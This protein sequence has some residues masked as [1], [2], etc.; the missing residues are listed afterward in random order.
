MDKKSKGKLG[1]QIDRDATKNSSFHKSHKNVAE[2][3]RLNIPSTTECCAV[4]TTG[5]TQFNTACTNSVLVTDDLKSSEKC[6]EN[7]LRRKSQDIDDSAKPVICDSSFSSLD[8][9]NFVI[10]CMKRWKNQCITWDPA[11]VLKS[12]TERKRT[13][14]YSTLEGIP[15]HCIVNGVWPTQSENSSRKLEN[16]LRVFIYFSRELHGKEWSLRSLELCENLTHVTLVR[17]GLASL[18]GIQCCRNL[19]HIDVSQNKISSLSLDGMF[20]IKSLVAASNRLTSTNG[21]Q[22]CTGLVHCDLSN[23]NI[24]KITGVEDCIDLTHLNLSN[25]QLIKLSGLENSKHLIFLEL[26]NNH[27]SSM[28]GLNA[29]GLLR[30]LDVSS[31]NFMKLVFEQLGNLVLLDR[32][33]LSRN[34][35]SEVKLDP[36]TSY[37]WLPCLTQLD[38]NRN[39]IS[40]ETFQVTTLKTMPLLQMVDFSENFIAD[41]E[42]LTESVKN[43]PNSVQF[44]FVSTEAIENPRF[45]KFLDAAPDSGLVSLKTVAQNIVSYK[46]LLSSE[47]S[48][49]LTLH[50]VPREDQFKPDFVT[51]H[52][53]Y[54]VKHSELAAKHR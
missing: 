30:Y 49:S 39:K 33:N 4:D 5:Q 27:L 23:N 46:H 31:N 28:H 37:V 54:L 21:V 3:V 22:G 10:N 20:R 34:N 35:I 15:E 44:N 29:C 1:T 26:S 9:E 13:P 18:H 12:S 2:K 36:E 11:R 25:N 50:K 24:T 7:T 40:E 8:H 47:K 48:E 6:T 32:L 19:K 41:S 38:L 17:C 14:H 45:L 53:D 42:T 52:C 16:L 51:N 43:L